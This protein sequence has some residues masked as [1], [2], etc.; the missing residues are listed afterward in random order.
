[1]YKFTDTIGDPESQ[2]LPAEALS[3]NGTY[4]ENEVAGY[5]TLSVSGR[6]LLESEIGELEI[7]HMTGSQYRYK[8]RPPREI[9]VTYQLLSSSPREF[10]ERYNKLCA[11]LEFEQ[12]RLVFLDEPDKYFIGTK[13]GVGS[14]PEGQL[15][16]TGTFVIYCT[17]P[18]KYAVDE[19]SFTAEANSDGILEVTIVNDGSVSAAVDY[20]IPH[21]HENG[22]LG[23]V[24]EYGAIQ[25]GNADEVDK[26]TRQKSQILACYKN[27]EDYAAMTDNQGMWDGGHSEYPKNGTWG[28]YVLKG[29]DWLGLT[30]V[31]SGPSWH[32][33]TKTITLPADSSGQTGASSFLA[34][35]RIAAETGLVPQ[36]G[37]LQMVIGDAS[38]K[39]LASMHFVKRSTTDNTASMV[40]QVQE[41]EIKR[42]KYEPTNWSST[43]NGGSNIYIRKMGELFEF[44]F[45]GQKYQFRYP[46]LKN[47]K[48]LTLTLCAGQFGDRGLNNLVTR[49][50]F[51]D[52]FFRK[53]NV[54]Y[55]YDI[56][57]RYRAGSK[58]SIEGSAAKVYVDGIPSLDDE[59]LGSKF[60]K[61]PPGE[62][63]VRFYYSSFSS[64]APTIT[65][66]IR[67][68]Y[69]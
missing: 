43:G 24:S 8:R 59:V 69:I 18:H 56:P 54:A 37:T 7:G 62:T 27:Y 14:V 64:P 6:E 17:D 53:D 10:R 32:G 66:R 23:I 15:N 48:A 19:K 11:L 2:S 21:N 51:R 1:M 44:Y 50:Y 13:K 58:V 25:L 3:I 29:M 55:L 49:M 67:E 31:G 9:T 4:I 36:T 47:T 46:A 38:G 20:E 68:A 42:I 16:V 40:M 33:A 52:T 5:T 61:V 22:Y 34:Q 26:E 35:T 45:A 39:H 63:K 28:R 57:N 41:K 12:A 30:S 65:A 60:F